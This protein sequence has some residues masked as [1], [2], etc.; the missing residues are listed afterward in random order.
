[1]IHCAWRDDVP[2]C[3]GI[4]SD[5]YFLNDDMIQYV[6]WLVCN[7]DMSWSL[8]TTKQDGSWLGWETSQ[9]LLKH[10]NNH[11]YGQTKWSKLL[12][13]VSGVRSTTTSRWA[14]SKFDI[15][16]PQVNFHN[17]QYENKSLSLYIYII[18]PPFANYLGGGLGFPN[19][20]PQLIR[21]CAS[22]WL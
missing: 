12:I 20:F 5:A 16:D 6:E 21:S 15:R 17:S 8:S 2:W 13:G 9:T 7:V 11:I 10:S 14:I 3:L 22:S 18:R 4:G 19:N 1:M